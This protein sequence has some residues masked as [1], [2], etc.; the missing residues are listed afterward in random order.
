V[1]SVKKTAAAGGEPTSTVSG[2]AQRGVGT[3]R[4]DQARRSAVTIPARAA[5]VESSRNAVAS[6]APEKRLPFPG[7]LV[8][9][10]TRDLHGRSSD[11]RSQRTL[12]S[13][14]TAI[15]IKPRRLLNLV[16]CMRPLPRAERRLSD[17][18]TAPRRPVRHEHRGHPHLQQGHRPQQWPSPVAQSTWKTARSSRRTALRWAAQ[19]QP[20]SSASSRGSTFRPRADQ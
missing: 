11:R 1:P 19:K 5:A 12:I 17:S 14:K 8:K 2:V 9:R 16:L 15:S 10:R 6:R 4:R 20:E 18:R 3:V 13:K 7:P